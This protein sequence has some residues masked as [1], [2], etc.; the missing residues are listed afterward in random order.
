MNLEEMRR[1]V[2]EQAALRRV[3]MLVAHGA[4]PAEVF[5][6][7][8]GEM[9]RVTGVDYTIIGRYCP[10]S[11]L[12]VV[13]TWERVLGADRTPPVGSIWPLDPD[14]TSGRVARTGRPTR[15][16]YD[17][18]T[19]EIARWATTHGCRSG[20]GCPILVEGRLWGVAIILSHLPQLP[21]DAIEDQMLGFI[22]TA[23]A[24]IANAES[25]DELAASRARVIAA[26]DATCRRI[27]RDLHDGVQ[28]RLIACGLQLQD[29]Q[30]NMPPAAEKFGRQLSIVAE[31]LTEVVEEVREISHGLHPVVLSRSGIGQA[32]KALARRSAIP[33]DLRMDADLRL[34]EAVEVALYY[35]VSEAL[36]NATKHAHASLV[37]VEL[38]ARNTTVR[39]SVH[40]N[41]VG[42]AC[43]DRGSGLVGLKDRVEA[44]GGVLEL[45]SPVSGGTTLSAEMP[46]GETGFSG[47]AR[48]H[49]TDRRAPA[50][51]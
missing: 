10:D 35:L 3:A 41:G 51:S 40:D 20:V 22:E 6:A 21:Q 46:T 32:L 23:G 44:I 34:P 27:E 1:I 49:G 43:F 13:A 39:V 36:T 31:C 4:P 5:N 7:V 25:H 9:G 48:H 42:G 47:R 17:G 30:A 37:R 19:G 2:E 11:T 26:T 15:V 12:A 28:Q 18:A 24:A 38:T 14:S 45:S 8:A 33:V 29:M 16:R 50:G